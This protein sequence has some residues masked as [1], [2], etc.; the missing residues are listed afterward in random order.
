MGQWVPGK[1]QHSSLHSVVMAHTQRSL[2]EEADEGQTPR[3]MEALTGATCRLRRCHLVMLAE[4]QGS[5]T[6]SWHQLHYLGRIL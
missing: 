1:D 5:G 6:M 2:V 3:E 4:T